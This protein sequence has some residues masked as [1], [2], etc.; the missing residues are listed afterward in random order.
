ML[1]RK[2]HDCEEIVAADNARLRELLHPDRDYQFSGRYSL[3][4]A[5][6]AA[7]EKSAKHSLASDEVYYILSGAGLLHVDDESAQVVA[8]DAVEIPHGSTQWIENKGDEELAFLCIVDP[9]WSASGEDVQ[10]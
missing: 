4:H 10:G 2:L 1:I 8:G 7:G 9:A 5:A 3:A 6:L